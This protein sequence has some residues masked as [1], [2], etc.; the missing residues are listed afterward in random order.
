MK[1]L[2][3]LSITLL[4]LV[5]VQTEQTYWTTRA[6]PTQVS[7]NDVYLLY[8]FCLP[9]DVIPTGV[10]DVEMY[11]QFENADYSEISID[12]SNDDIGIA[13]HGNTNA[14]TLYLN[15]AATD[16]NWTPIWKKSL[17]AVSFSGLIASRVPI[18]EV[19][20]AILSDSFEPLLNTKSVCSI[21]ECYQDIDSCGV[22]GGDDSTC[23]YSLC[24]GFPVTDNEMASCQFQLNYFGEGEVS[25]FVVFFSLFPVILIPLCFCA[26]LQKQKKKLETERVIQELQDA[27]EFQPQPEQEATLQNLYPQFDN[28]NCY[29]VEGPN[30]EQFVYYGTPQSMM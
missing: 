2:A 17:K 6:I 3:L 10:Y 14:L 29:L 24:N 12:W 5:S 23:A 7:N 19:K 8:S 30:G 4:F 16:A 18:T 11:I 15:S 27:E 28:G 1:A 9:I 22:C 26:I 20:F 13:Y 21:D 25:S